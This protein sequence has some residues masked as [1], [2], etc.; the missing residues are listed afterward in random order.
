MRNF[1][2][3]GI[4][5]FAAASALVHVNGDG[6]GFLVYGKSFERASLN[7][8]I[9]FAL[10]AQVGKFRAWNQHKHANS[11]RFRPDF[12]FVMQRAGYFAFAAA[13]TSCEFSAYPDWISVLYCI[14]NHSLPLL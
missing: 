2:W 5:A 13:A 10:R 8:W 12:I 14:F 9:I 11:R 7:A 1:T 3:A 4:N 6:A